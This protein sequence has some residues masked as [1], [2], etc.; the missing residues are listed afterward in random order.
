MNPKSMIKYHKMMM[1]IWLALAI[2]S[3]SVVISLTMAAGIKETWLYYLLPVF[4]FILFLIR[5]SLVE[6]I[7][8]EHHLE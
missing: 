1:W 3:L 2:M 4:C 8:K 6:K 5:R 7:K